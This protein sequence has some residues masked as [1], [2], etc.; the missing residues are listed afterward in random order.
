[1]GMGISVLAEAQKEIRAR[2]AKGVNAVP[3][4]KN[5]SKQ[6]ENRNRK[7]SKPATK[8]DGT[9]MKVALGH[10]VMRKTGD[11]LSFLVHSAIRS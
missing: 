7:Q 2:W 8:A 3:K 6:K 9:F 5:E 11:S 10:F 1:M 4:K